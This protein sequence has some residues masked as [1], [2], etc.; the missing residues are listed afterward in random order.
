MSRFFPNHPRSPAATAWSRAARHLKAREDEDPI[1][2]AS[3]HWRSI[4]GHGLARFAVTV[5]TRLAPGIV[6]LL[7]GADE[8]ANHPRNVRSFTMYGL[9][10]PS[11]FSYAIGTLEIVGALALISGIALL[12]VAVALAADMVGAIVV[13][14]IALG[15]LIS[16]TLAPAM[17]VAMLVL[18]ARELSRRRAGGEPDGS[19]VS[20]ANPKPAACTGARGPGRRR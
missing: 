11:L 1:A 15:E 19:L 7:F 17:L 18:I 6:F 8:F 10:S 4:D 5:G 9:P 14:G 12:P 16:L 20:R 2:G 13:S 3:L